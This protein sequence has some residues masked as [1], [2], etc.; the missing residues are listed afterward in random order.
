MQRK[1]L[2]YVLCSSKGLARAVIVLFG[3]L[4]IWSQ[5]AAQI[6]ISSSGSPG[7]SYA[8]GV[9][10]GIGGMGPNIGLAYSGGG[11]NGPVGH[12]WSVQG[13]SAITRCPSTVVVDGTAGAVMFMPTD[14]LCLDG[15]RL[16]QVSSTGVAVA[17]TSDDAA[18]IVGGGYREFRTE[19]DMFARIRAYGVARNPDGSSSFTNPD[20][21]IDTNGNGPGNFKVWTKSGQIYEYGTQLITISGGTADED[22]QAI[23]RAQGQ[24]AVAVW[25]AHRISDVVGNYI[26]FKYTQGDVSWGSSTIST[27]AGGHEWNIA[28]IQYTGNASQMPYNKIVF[29]YEDRSALAQPAHDRAE[30]YQLN[31]KNVSV[32]RLIAIRTYVNTPNPD[33][34]GPAAS[35]IPVRVVKMNYERGTVSGRSRVASIVDCAGSDETKCVPGPKFNYE[36]G[37]PVGFTANTGFGTASPSLATL[38][39]T[40]SAGGYGVITGDF[41]GDGRT[42]IIRW[43]NTASENQL[44]FSKGGGRFEMSTAFN[45][46]AD[47]LFSNDACYYS[48][49]ADFNGDGLSDI[50]RVAKAGCS[51][52]TNLLFLSVGNGVFN[53]VVL[54][55]NIDLENLTPVYSATTIVCGNPLGVGADVVNS[56]EAPASRP[57]NKYVIPPVDSYGQTAQSA[58]KKIAAEP[59]SNRQSSGSLAKFAAVNR[60]EY[61]SRTL[62]KRF[63]LFDANGDG[64]LDIVTTVLPSYS[65]RSADGLRPNDQQLCRGALGYGGL[66]SR[67]YLGGIDGNFTEKTN[68]NI[69]NTTVYSNPPDRRFNPNPYWDSP[70]V[71]DINGDGLKDILSTGSGRWRSTGDGNFVGSSIQDSSQLCGL[72]IDF[73]GDGRMDCLMPDALGANQNMTVSFG[74]AASTAL[75]QF[76]LTASGDNL[77]AADANK[78]QTVGVLID[79]F[80]GDGRQDILR[81]GPTPADNGIYLSN[82]DASFRARTSAGLDSISRPLQSADGSTSFVTGDFL[83][84]GSLQILH[85][86]QDPAATGDVVANTNQLYQK[87]DGPMPDQLVSVISPS[88]LITT[89]TYA[90][91]T[92]ESDTTALAERRYVSDRDAGQ[93]ASYPLIDLKPAMPVVVTSESDTGIAGNKVKTEYAYRGMKAALDGRGLLGFRQSVQQNF[94]PNGEPLSVWTNYLLD[95]PYIGVAKTTE[96]RRGSWTEPNASLLS[97]TINVYCDKTS[98]T[99]AL[100]T[101]D[102]LIGADPAALTENSPCFTTAEIKRPYLRRSVEAG[103]DLAGVPLPTVT[104]INSYNDFGDPNKIWVTTTGKVAGADYTYTKTTANT[105]CA[106]GSALADGSVCPNKIDGDLWILGRL[107]S[108]TVTNSVPN[109]MAALSAGAGPRPNA[110]A[111]TGVAPSNAPPPPLN[112]AVLAAILQFLLED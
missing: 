78:R 47:K 81:W 9:P 104:T 88:G 100:L 66:C 109:L 34:T 3:L 102:P 48:I 39:M 2:N 12:G 85:L 83:G 89:L 10:P 96:T 22:R 45:I 108:S 74:A 31:S 53:S 27:N 61:S 35:R 36:N 112:P 75:L 57:A 49:V 5:A 7:Y 41:N 63:Y 23:I 106:P 82:G 21:T 111:T 15:Q 43:S 56:Q 72:P 29:S 110:A 64:K 50:L 14:R 59:G 37:A 65:W 95:A 52:S 68:T 97:K 25:A 30:A 19:K 79:D 1:N 16:I 40:D 20:G 58:P 38:K 80:D 70:N 90:R 13:I 69:A 91:L 107:N 44:W 105:F 94:G 77:Y 33:A 84:I 73:N 42:D 24:R 92:A 6:G 4:A 51:P 8:I 18:G 93:P 103:T 54:P 55:S 67:V 26:N 32:K 99:D 87:V 98:A 11:V 60:C 101:A 28:E 86:K 17:A 76:N 62:G 71:A 46:T